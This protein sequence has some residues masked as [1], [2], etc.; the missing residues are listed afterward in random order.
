MSKSS[1]KA[2]ERTLGLLYGLV[3]Y[4]VFLGT[5]L[6]AIGFVGN[7]WPVLGLDSTWFRSMDID[8]TG[9]SLGQ[10]LLVNA[11]LLSVFAVQHSGMARRGFK[12]WWTRIVPK[13]FERSTYVLAASLC[14]CLL[15]AYWRPMGTI[16]L[17]DVS[18]GAA[19]R[20]LSAVSIAGWAIVFSSTFMIDHFDLFG[21][22]QAWLAFRGRSYTEHPFKT[23][24]LYRLVR[25]PIYLG[26]IIAFWA[27]P[28]M[29]IGHL[30]FAGATT[31]YIVVAIQLEERD[32]V[33]HYGDLYREYRQRVHMLAPLPRGKEAAPVSRAPESL[34][35]TR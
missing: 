1:L 11:A 15:F 29:T 14:L 5:I 27:T 16:V 10:A 33:H 23:P 8:T 30:L 4:A 2:S 34:K 12:Q 35:P 7:L 20:A 18:S 26:F 17:W 19:G 32:L 31:I 25:H 9:S 21:L 24:G 6:Y 22:R 13:E 3:A 28:V